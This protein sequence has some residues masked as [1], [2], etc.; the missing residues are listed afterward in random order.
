V[1]PESPAGPGGPAYATVDAVRAVPPP[2]AGGA[3]PQAQILTAMGLATAGGGDGEAEV[4]VQTDDGQT[5]SVV[6]ADAAGL[7]PGDRV[8]VIPGAVPR[9]VRPGAGSPAS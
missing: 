4:V 6:G 3:S 5:L 9:L 7:A 1:A 8:L 2:A